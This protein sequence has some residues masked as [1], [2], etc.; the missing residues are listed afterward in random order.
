MRTGHFTQLVWKGSTKLGV[1][2]AKQGSTVVVVARYT[3]AGNF[4]GRYQ[5]NVQ[6]RKPGGKLIF[7]FLTFVIIANLKIRDEQF[8][9]TKLENLIHNSLTAGHKLT[10]Q[11]MPYAV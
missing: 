4:R 6:R 7:T 11:V 5:E 3:P 9:C 1:G 2:I 8:Y 10:F